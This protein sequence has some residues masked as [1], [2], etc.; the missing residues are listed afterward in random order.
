MSSG[1]EPLTPLVDPD[2]EWG[3]VRGR[4]LQERLAIVH[5]EARAVRVGIRPHHRHE[6]PVAGD[7][8]SQLTRHL[9]AVSGRVVEAADQ[10]RMAMLRQ[11]LVT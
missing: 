4:Q 6:D 8:R 7:R 2:F 9:Q 3:A 10:H 1:Y 5:R 11:E